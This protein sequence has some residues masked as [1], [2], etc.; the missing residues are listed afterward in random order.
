MLLIL[1]NCKI[2]FLFVSKVTWSV[3]V[4]LFVTFKSFMDMSFNITVNLNDSKN[5]HF[6]VVGNGKDTEKTITDN[7][8]E[9]WNFVE[10][11]C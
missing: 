8:I 10:L 4:V 5:V 3:S 2:S 7:N 1:Q 6:S 11:R 9:N